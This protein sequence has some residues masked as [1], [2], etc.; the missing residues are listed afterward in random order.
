VF[1]LSMSRS[2]Y[3]QQY[4]FRRILAQNDGGEIMRLQASIGLAA[5]IYTGSGLQLTSSQRLGLDLVKPDAITFAAH[6]GNIAYDALK[7]TLK[8]HLPKSTTQTETAEVVGARYETRDHRTGMYLILESQGLADEVK[9]IYGSLQRFGSD[10]PVLAPGRL[11]VHVASF[12]TDSLPDVQAALAEQE[13]FSATLQPLPA[14]PQAPRI[15]PVA[16]IA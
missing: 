9:S 11:L 2:S 14:V 15:T 4:P 12:E 8:G 13:Q 5:G 10:V 7:Q 1:N 3:P 6:H 16:L